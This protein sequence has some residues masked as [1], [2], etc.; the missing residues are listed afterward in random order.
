MTLIELI[1]SKSPREHGTIIELLQAIGDEEK[2]CNVVYY[3]STGRPTTNEITGN[4]EVVTPSA[5]TTQEA[6]NGNITMYEGT[7][8]IVGLNTYASTENTI[9]IGE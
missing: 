2:K 8:T 3:V 4:I 1:K 7:A 6:I 9:E 5:D